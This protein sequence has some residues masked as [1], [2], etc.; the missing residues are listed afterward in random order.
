MVSVY[1]HRRG[2]HNIS[3]EDDVVV[4]EAEGSESYQSGEY[5]NERNVTLH[6]E[7]TLEQVLEAAEEIKNND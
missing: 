3:V 6:V 4:V 1:N 2:I 5:M 7:L